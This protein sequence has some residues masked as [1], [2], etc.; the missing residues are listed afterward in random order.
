MTERLD[1]TVALITGASSG[2]GEATA[3][4]LAAQGAAVALAAR[5]KQRLEQLA[6]DIIGRGGHAFVIETDVT[7]KAQAQFAV[8]QTV[9]ELGRLDILCRAY[10]TQRRGCVRCD[11][12]WRRRVQRIVASGGHKTACSRL[13]HRAWGRCD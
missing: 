13:G 11:Q 9:A 8:E 5:R 2:I 6:Q 10:R 1:G 12:V 4:A 3:R 7:Q